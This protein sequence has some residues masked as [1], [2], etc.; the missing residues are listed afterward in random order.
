MSATR[1]LPTV[2][3]PTENALRALLVHVLSDSAICTYEAWVAM[4][5]AA[6]DAAEGPGAMNWRAALANRLAKP[7]PFVD[8]V[9]ERLRKAGL[10]DS[11]G[12]VTDRGAAELAAARAAVG[13][14]SSA[15]VADIPQ[16]DQDVARRVLDKIRLNAEDHLRAATR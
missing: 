2:I 6:N 5:S 8:E 4:S 10:I 15:V 13:E 12:A 9:V 7:L 14:V 11:S 1:P 16:P 3:G